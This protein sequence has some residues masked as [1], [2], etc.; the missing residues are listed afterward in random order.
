MKS[1][2]INKLLPALLIVSTVLVGASSI[3][4]TRVTDYEYL[5][6]KLTSVHEYTLE[7]FEAMPAEDFAF[8][9]SEDVRTFSAQAFHIAYSTEFFKKRFNGEQ[10][11]W[12]PGDENRMTKEELISYFD[13]Q[14]K[15][16][17]EFIMAQD[18]NPQLTAGIVSFLD[19]HSHHRG[20]MITYL[21]VSGIEPPQYR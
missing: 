20:Q 5:T 16:M 8:K 2:P 12:E 6:Q 18:A 21:R 19:H 7:V 9:P 14:F 10:V 3:D 17:S 13:T 1:I 11:A 15:E 4:S